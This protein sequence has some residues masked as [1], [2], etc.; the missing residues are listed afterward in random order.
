MWFPHPS[1]TF[2]TRVEVIGIQREG[3]RADGVCVNESTCVCAHPRGA[4]SVSLP[5]DSPAAN[6]KARVLGSVSD[7]TARE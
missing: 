2:V 3:L 4:V 5:P 7:I 1:L 6:R